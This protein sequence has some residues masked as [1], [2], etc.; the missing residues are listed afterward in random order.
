MTVA[1]QSGSSSLRPGVN[2]ATTCALERDFPAA[3]LET[4]CTTADAVPPRWPEK[5]VRF[6][7]GLEPERHAFLKGFAGQAGVG[8]A[9]VLRALLGEL[10]ADPDLATRVGCG[11]LVF[12]GEIRL[13][14][15]V[16]FAARIS[17]RTDNDITIG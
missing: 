6:T 12:S 16:Q 17:C 11:F 8:S 2:T 3:K 14:F 13:V 10:R 15:G 9:Q 5:P 1:R 4:S 7:L